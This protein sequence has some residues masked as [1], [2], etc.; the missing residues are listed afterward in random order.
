M[1]NLSNDSWCHSWDLSW[2]VANQARSTTIWYLIILWLSTK[3]K[4]LSHLAPTNFEL[5]DQFTCNLSCVMALETVPCL[6][7]L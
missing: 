2:A 5:L 6:Y 7:D 4:P 3:M 1:K